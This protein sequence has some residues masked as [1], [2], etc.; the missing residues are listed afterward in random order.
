[1][2]VKE[3]EQADVNLAGR[4]LKSE[5][6]KWKTYNDSVEVWQCKTELQKCAA[7]KEGSEEPEA[8]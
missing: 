6:A 4:K 2:A 5:V 3:H 8:H 7:H 1:M